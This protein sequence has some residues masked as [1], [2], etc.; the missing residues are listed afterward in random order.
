MSNYKEAL[1]KIKAFA[2]DVDGVFSDCKI[3][4]NPTGEMVRTM[5]I[6][7]GYA[8]QLAVKKGYPIAVITG[9][10]SRAVKKRFSYLGVKFIYL[11]SASK[12]AD[13]NDFLKRNNL[14][15]SE[16]LYMGDDIPDLEVMK[17]AGFAACPADAAE[18]VKQVAHYISDKTG[19]SGCVRDIMEQVMKLQEKWL[20]KDAFYW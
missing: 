13:F 10:H 14:Q 3:N 12:M 8:V 17:V 7:D 18:E 4:L 5:N 6:K 20:D 9:G 16:V 1:G 19:G 15:A 11:H 2:F